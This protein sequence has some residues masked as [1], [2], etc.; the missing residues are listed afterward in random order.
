MEKPPIENSPEGKSEKEQKEKEACIFISEKAEPL[1]KE[2]KESLNKDNDF[3]PVD[4]G[5]SKR[6]SIENPSD[7]MVALAQRERQESENF[8]DQIKHKNEY[9]EEKVANKLKVFLKKEE[10]MLRALAEIET[11][12]PELSQ[13][14]K[15]QKPY[16]Q[17]KINN[18]EKEWRK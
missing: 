14:I 1:F 7:Y 6:Y 8:L 15:V 17:E 13:L 11:Q 4:K 2:A 5:S 18:S 10:T 12:F 9:Y 16:L 3:S